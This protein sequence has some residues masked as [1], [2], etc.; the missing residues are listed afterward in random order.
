MRTKCEG[1]S[2]LTEVYYE[3]PDDPEKY[4]WHCFYDIYESKIKITKP[5]ES[6][7]EDE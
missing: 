7:Q 6:E 2:I 1:C 4:C 3:F 5:K